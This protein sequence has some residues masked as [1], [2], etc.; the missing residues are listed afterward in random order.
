[1]D[2]NKIFLRN[3]ISI[4]VIFIILKVLERFTFF[5]LEKY[6][7]N[8]LFIMTISLF[9]LL[10]L[11]TSERIEKLNFLNI[12]K[13][14]FLISCG[15]LLI[16]VSIFSLSIIKLIR[17]QV[18]EGTFIYTSLLVYKGFIPIL[19]FY[20]GPGILWPYIYGL[21][22]ILLGSSIFLG[23]ATS[24]VFFVGDIILATIISFALACI[25]SF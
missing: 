6:I 9:I 11:M 18:E 20:N 13:K 16:F 3:L 8:E 23:R 19:D 10:T 25:G 1:M 14:K 4:S 17:L 12:N 21:I 2:A 5:N 22:Q 7:S 15:F 24:F